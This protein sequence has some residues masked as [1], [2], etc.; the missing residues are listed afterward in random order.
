MDHLGPL[1]T[2]GVIDRAIKAPCVRLLLQRAADWRLHHSN[3]DEDEASSAW[4]WHWVTCLTMGKPSALRTPSAH[5]AHANRG[6]VL[7][8]QRGPISV[9]SAAVVGGP[10]AARRL[11]W[12]SRLR[13]VVEL[14]WGVR[15]LLEYPFVADTHVGGENLDNRFVGLACWTWCERAT[16]TL[17]SFRPGDD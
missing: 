10:L 9:R 3:F 7:T 16:W 12:R 17:F 11:R 15:R 14:A 1:I 8:K 4:L 13:H 5:E 6:G 2:H